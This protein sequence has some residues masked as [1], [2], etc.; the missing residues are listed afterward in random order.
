[1]ASFH[2]PFVLFVSFCHCK[3]T[4]CIQLS[5][6]SLLSLRPRERSFSLRL[7]LWQLLRPP[8]ALQAPHYLM[9]LRSN[10]ILFWSQS[11]HDS[12]TLQRRFGAKKAVWRSFICSFA[13]KIQKNLVAV[14]GHA[15]P[16]SAFRPSNFARAR[17]VHKHDVR[18]DIQAKGCDVCIQDD[19]RPKT[20][21]HLKA[22][23]PAACYGALLQL[24]SRHSHPP[25]T[26]AAHLYMAHVIR[27]RPSP[28]KRRPRTRG[29]RGA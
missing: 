6:A 13:P 9:H 26:C 5:F 12:K 27:Q 17:R 7:N 18:G 16:P 29:C 24:H 25:A 4:S 2:Q 19:P 3:L 1:M 14:I 21:A 23:T 8:I 20:T 10:R 28:L 15:S 22:S 11:H